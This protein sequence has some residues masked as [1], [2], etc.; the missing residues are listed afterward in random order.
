MPPAVLVPIPQVSSQ[1]EQLSILEARFAEKEPSDESQEVWEL[2]LRIAQLYGEVAEEYRRCGNSEVPATILEK[3][4][5]LLQ[6]LPS[7]C[8]LTSC[9]RWSCLESVGLA[10]AFAPTALLPSCSRAPREVKA[11]LH[12]HEGK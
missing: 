2:R 3:A 7:L 6:A 1:V 10:G 5:Q 11:A 8:Q 4:I 12:R 9:K